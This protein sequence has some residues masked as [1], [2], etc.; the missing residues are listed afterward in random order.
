MEE[1]K[2]IFIINK[3]ENKIIEYYLQNDI[4][5]KTLY[6][7]KECMEFH[8]NAVYKF[9]NLFNHEISINSI[10]I[11]QILRDNISLYITNADE[12]E[13]VKCAIDSIAFD[14]GQINSPEEFF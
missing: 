9:Y 2:K 7:A 8:R 4:S 14:D 5:K 3:I 10:S 1:L 11:Y 12:C 6:E 13:I